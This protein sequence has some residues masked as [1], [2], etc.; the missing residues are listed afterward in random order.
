MEMMAVVWGVPPGSVL[1]SYSLSC[2]IQMQSQFM[3]V[4]FYNETKKGTLC[5]FFT[6]LV[7]KTPKIGRRL[8]SFAC[9][10]PSFSMILLFHLTA[11][12]I[13]FTLFQRCFCLPPTPEGVF[14]DS[15]FE[16]GRGQS[17]PDVMENARR[18]CW[19]TGF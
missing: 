17:A 7:S 18:V 11:M 4:L 1:G 3:Y 6:D 13:T 12:L 19:Q 14:T 5:F 9:N 10:H 2:S 15:I 16:N 8:P